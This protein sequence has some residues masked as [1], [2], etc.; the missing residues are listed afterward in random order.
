LNMA[1]GRVSVTTAITSIMSSFDKWY[2][3]SAGPLMHG[4]LVSRVCYSV[5]IFAPVAVTATVCS[6]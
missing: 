5:R 1:F 2:P 6:K 4:Q 3:A